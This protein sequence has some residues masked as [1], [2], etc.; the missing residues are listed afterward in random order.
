MC[1]VTYF[2]TQQ[3]TI[4][5][6]SRDEHLSRPPAIAPAPYL[7]KG[8]ELIYPK[9]PK[10]GGSWLAI[11]PQGRVAVLMN[12]A[13]NTHVSNPPYR[14]SRGLIL[15]DM[16]QLEDFPFNILHYPLERIEPFTVIWTQGNLLYQVR[17]DGKETDLVQLPSENPMIWSSST[18]YNLEMQKERQSWF[19]HWQK[20]VFQKRSK[21]EIELQEWQQE[22][23]DF[24]HNTA[25][26]N[27]EFG[28]QID[29]PNGMKTGSITS[30]A[31]H[32]KAGRCTLQY[33]DLL[34][35]LQ[36]NSQYSHPIQSASSNYAEK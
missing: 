8:I 20:A 34:N 25:T 16:I 17:W 35:N 13:K 6:S 24:H 18:L 21:Q 10:G 31:L 2:P 12:G 32:Q 5:T 19:E 33:Y 11:H 23:I 28:L 22:L 4:V 30:V 9:D 1:T 27:K 29:R 3:G 14:L 26:N 7:H 36:H 15:L